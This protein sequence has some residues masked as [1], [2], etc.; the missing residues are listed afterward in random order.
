MIAISITRE[1]YEAIRATLPD[2]AESWP[3]Q[4]DERGLIRVWLD[5]PFV[6][7]LGQCAG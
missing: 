3:V 4:T 5:R 1:A 6:D 7:R 2:A